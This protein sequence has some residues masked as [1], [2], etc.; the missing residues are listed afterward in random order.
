MITKTELALLVALIVV[1]ITAGIA[2]GPGED[3]NVEY[4]KQ[5]LVVPEKY[6]DR[7]PPEC[8]GEYF[9]ARQHE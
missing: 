7:V 3:P 5:Y 6:I 9:K 8:T 1:L 4:C 2:M